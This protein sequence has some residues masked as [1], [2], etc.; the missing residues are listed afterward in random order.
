VTDTSTPPVVRLRRRLRAPVER[1]FAAW[2]DPAS[3]G[4]WMSPVGFA[5]AELDPRVGGRL[6]V[7]MVADDVS[8]EHTGEYLEVVPSRRLVF[9]WRSPFTG[10]DSRVTVELVERGEETDL[11]LVHEFLPG[12]AVA[13]HE[14]GWTWMLDRLATA[15]ELES[16]DGG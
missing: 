11:V 16:T 14:D 13:S 9:T 3:V 15:L 6:R 4:R 7:V 8:L 5:I 2:T 1:V 10:D 12:D